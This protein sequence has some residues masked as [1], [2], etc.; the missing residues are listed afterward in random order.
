[1]WF[2]TIILIGRCCSRFTKP[3][4]LLYLQQVIHIAAFMTVGCIRSFNSSQR[5][6]I[7]FLCVSVPPSCVPQQAGLFTEGLRCSLT[8]KTLIQHIP[9][10]FTYRERGV[11]EKTVCVCVCERDR[12]RERAD[13]IS[14][15][16]TSVCMSMCVCYSVCRVHQEVITPYLSGHR[17]RDD[18]KSVQLLSEMQTRNEGE[19]IEIK[20][21]ADQREGTPFWIPIK[22]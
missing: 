22:F 12:D 20:R 4:Q 1:M 5:E 15:H 9:S 16:W 18:E 11:G 13:M 8:E 2:Y 17:L 7:S 14:S 10:M 3:F 6:D 21:W 19:F